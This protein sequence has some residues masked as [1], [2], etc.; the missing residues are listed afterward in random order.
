[1]T[2]GLALGAGTIP[3]YPVYVDTSDSSNRFQPPSNYP[4]GAGYL[5]QSRHDEAHGVRRGRG[6]PRIDEGAARSD[7][8]YIDRRR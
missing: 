4:L 5:Q 2:S 3:S 7:Y 1:M 8:G 6:L